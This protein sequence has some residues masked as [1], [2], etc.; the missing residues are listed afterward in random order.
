MTQHQSTQTMPIPLHRCLAV[1]AI[2]MALSLTGCV[3][4][5]EVS[6]GQYTLFTN[7]SFIKQRNTTPKKLWNLAK[8]TRA[9][10]EAKF[11]DQCPGAK[12]C[13]DIQQR[14]EF[15]SQAQM[16]LA[17]LK[18]DTTKITTI[19]YQAVQKA[20]NGSSE[21]KPERTAY[22]LPESF[23]GDTKVQIEEGIHLIQGMTAA[24]NT[25]SPLFKKMDKGVCD[26]FG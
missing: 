13:Q 17:P 10:L 1:V 18:G 16:G 7:W 25:D 5:V 22:C 8:N 11:Q 20:A 9:E 21:P 14:L 19:R 12:D 15:A 24:K 23:T 26:T 3:R 4:Q 6:D 2:P